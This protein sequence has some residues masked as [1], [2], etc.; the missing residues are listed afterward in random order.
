MNGTQF[1]HTLRRWLVVLAC[2]SAPHL[3]HA[4]CSATPAMPNLQTLDTMAVTANLAV[5]STIPGTLRSYQFSGACTVWS[6][7]VVPGAPI[8]ACYYGSGS[9]VMP[10]VYST[11]VQ[12]LGIRLRNAAGQP[13]TNA[14]GL[15]C[16]TRT[17]NL[18][19]LNPDMT[20]AISVSIEFVKTGPIAAGNLDPVQTRFGFGVFN[21]SVQGGLG[22]TSNYIGFAG[23]I[24]LREITCNLSYP[25]VVGLPAITA[26]T[27]ARQGV[28]G[29]TPFAIQL[30]CGGDAIVGMTLDGAA[31]TP[32]ISAPAGILGLSNAGAA[33]TAGG[34]GVQIVNAGGTAPVPLQVRNAMGNI[35][36]RVPATYR[37]GARYAALGGT[38]SPGNVSSAMVFT[39]DY[40]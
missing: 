18:G 27:L 5:G 29:S 2:M 14:A 26:N 22:G 34:A 4:V 33:G 35:M 36:A 23:A 32:V 12:G 28:S 19:S 15:R 37:F 6:T 9:E 1:L 13:V 40:Q 3:A 30:T 20:Y 24:A 17:A 7:W 38:P 39:M 8:I 10:G 31:G 25:S 11:G 16:D 21:G